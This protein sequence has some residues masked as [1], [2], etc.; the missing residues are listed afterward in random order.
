MRYKVPRI[1]LAE[2]AAGE[3]GSCTASAPGTLALRPHHPLT[4][5][6]APGRMSPASEQWRGREWGRGPRIARKSG[7]YK[8]QSRDWIVPSPLLPPR[9]ERSRGFVPE[10]TF[11]DVQL[12]L[13]ASS[14]LPRHLVGGSDY[15]AM[16][17]QIDSQDE[18][19]V[20]VTGF[21]VGFLHLHP[22]PVPFPDCPSFPTPPC[23]RSVTTV[24]RIA[25]DEG[26]RAWLHE[27]KHP[28]SQNRYLVG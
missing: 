15:F 10:A 7:G 22:A 27:N 23:R 16:G 19:T 13:L 2:V 17:S 6:P 14:S 3:R 21:G 1:A 5:H 12:L 28:P 9:L 18:F 4:A 20:L 24:H 8:R 11:V 25:T 26:R